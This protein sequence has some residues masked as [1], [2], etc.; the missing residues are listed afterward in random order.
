MNN[1]NRV[2]ELLTDML[3]EHKKTNER[4]AK[5]N[6]VLSEMRLA[7]MKFADKFVLVTNIEERVLKLEK[8]V[9]QN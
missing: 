2:I 6:I 5:T 9:F 4:L 1:D 7:F 8:A 3:Q